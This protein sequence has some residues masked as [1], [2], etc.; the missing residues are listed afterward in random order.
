[1]NKPSILPNL[2]VKQL[3]TGEYG[4]SSSSQIRTG[5]VIEYCAWIPV[6]QKMQILIS[7]ND[8]TFAKKLFINQD[9][10]D[11]ERDIAAKVAELDLQTRLDKGILTPE[12]VKSILFSV[13]NPS[14]IAD[15][16]SHAILLGFGSIYR[17]SDT[18]NI[19]W[20]YDPIS[21]LYKFYAVQDILANQELTYFS[22]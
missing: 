9:G 1:M 14:A 5:T 18:P 12:Q 3:S 16:V 13:A 19:N 15:I 2:Y 8:G 4:V 11:K 10:I 7:K 6:T 21:K 17:R 20:E 22:N